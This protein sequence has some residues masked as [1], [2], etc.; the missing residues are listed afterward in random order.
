MDVLKTAL[1]ESVLE[2]CFSE[3]F[4]HR[5]SAEIYPLF[6]GPS[7]ADEKLFVVLGSDSGLLL[8]YLATIATPDQRFICVEYPKVIEY[9]QQ[10]R[11]SLLQGNKSF[12]LELHNIEDFELEDLYLKHHDYVTRNA[13][14]LLTSLVVAEDKGIYAGIFED[15]KALFERF[16]IDRAD[17]RDYKRMFDEQLESTCDL[18]HPLSVIKERLKGDIPGILLGGGP[19]LD[20]V[21]PWLKENQHK[22][23][24]F[25]ASR[26]CKRLLKEG[27]TPDF[28]GMV[29]SQ[30]LMFEYSKEMYEFQNSSI[31]ITG[32]HPYPRL[33]RQWSGLKMYSRRRFPWV[34]GSEDNF[35]YD[36]PT[37]SNALFGIATYLGVTNF[38]LAGVDF[39]YTSEGVCHESGSI[40]SKNQQ[41]NSLDTTA[42]NYRGEQVGTSIQLYD[43]RNLFE[44]QFL[45]LREKWP[46]LQAHNLND[47]AA[48]MAG[49]DYLPIENVLLGPDKFKVVEAFQEALQFDASS[50]KSFQLFLNNEVKSHSRWLSKVA[51]ES[52]KGLHLSAILFADPSKKAARIKEVLKLKVKLEKLVGVDY[53]TMVNYGYKAFMAS[54]KPVDCETDM[55][56]QEMINSLIGFFGG[57][58]LAA[59]DFLLKLEDVKNEIEF[60]LLELDPKT[61]FKILSSH[62]L[63]RR[64]PGRL[65]VWLEHYATQPYSY[66]Q[67]QYAETVAL[68]ETGFQKMKKDETLLEQRFK[69][70]L[71]QPEDFI[72]RLQ[73]AF[74]SNELYTVQDII[75]QLKLIEAPAY[76]VVMSYATGLYLELNGEVNDALIHYQN[77]DPKRQVMI[78]QQQI[79]RLA[80][81]LQRYEKGLEPLAALSHMDSRYWPK[82]AEALSMLGDFKGAVMAYQAYPFLD[83]DT[84]AMINFLRLLVQQGD[85]EMANSYLQALEGNQKIDQVQLQDFVDS[86]NTPT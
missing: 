52:K 44:T 5:S 30:P 8:D 73:N 85:V 66:Y 84:V 1:N 29:D 46:N 40:E 82:Y 22:V 25:A 38:Y 2:G 39:C 34:R 31:L 67:N 54:L 9:L 33:I 80:F 6:I 71:D 23:W 21:I 51:Q 27:V 65:Y 35:M 75:R 10:T 79:V 76:Q 41:R 11:N 18:V 55:S 16:K 42:I 19:S 17:N 4:N 78:L 62:W 3:K 68:L 20:D 74:E 72:S 59:K 60:R 24:I 64:E 28:I 49:I 37:I 70:R 77:I 7:L 86:L 36:G 15:F 61:D 14:I 53:Q 26:I 13:V 83:E 43:A 12:K 48:V 81:S 47:G 69:Q 50:E 57:L 56:Q 63:N 58:N 45:H 32:E